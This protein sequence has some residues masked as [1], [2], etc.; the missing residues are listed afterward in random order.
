MS[1]V[2]IVMA[3]AR[4]HPSEEVMMEMAVR[5]LCTVRPALAVVR[6]GET[7]PLDVS[8]AVVEDVVMLERLFLMS[9]P[10]VSATSGVLKDQLGVMTLS[11]WGE[12]STSTD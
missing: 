10:H 4:S 7:R 1:S 9:C 8:F 2:L 3:S 12:V 6:A 11:L 5:L